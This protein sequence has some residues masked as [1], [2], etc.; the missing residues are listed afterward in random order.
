VGG[1]FFHAG[2][3]GP[4][5]NG[6]PW[7]RRTPG[8]S[9][10]HTT[11]VLAPGSSDSLGDWVSIADDEKKLHSSGPPIVHGAL[12][13]GHRLSSSSGASSAIYHADYHVPKMS[14]PKRS[15]LDAERVPGPHKE[16]STDAKNSPAQGSGNVDV[17]EEDLLEQEEAER[18]MDEFLATFIENGEH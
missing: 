14:N 18:I 7:D 13:R 10:K 5:M 8:I 3:F 2:L 6:D 1:S 11:T 15:G 17:E 12:R 16:A 4:G 9:P